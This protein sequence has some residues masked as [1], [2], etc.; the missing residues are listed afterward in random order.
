M[1]VASNLSTTPNT[2]IA[3]LPCANAGP[4]S[5]ASM[6]PRMRALRMGGFLQVLE[7]HARAQLFFT[8]DRGGPHKARCLTLAGVNYSLH[9][10][11][12]S[13]PG[14]GRSGCVLGFRSLRRRLCW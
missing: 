4:A 5:N 6:D 8:T 13:E 9:S 14:V 7:A 2:L 1:L 10:R 3:L 11:T 12:Y